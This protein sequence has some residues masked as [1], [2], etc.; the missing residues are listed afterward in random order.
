MG[1]NGG[2]VGQGARAEDRMAASVRIEV[3]WDKGLKQSGRLL[4]SQLPKIKTVR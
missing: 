1:E 4:H 2:W 3:Q